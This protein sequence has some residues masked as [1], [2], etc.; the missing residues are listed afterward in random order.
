MQPF[1]SSTSFPPTYYPALTPT[2]DGKLDEGLLGKSTSTKGVNVL[3][4]GIPLDARACERT[5]ARPAPPKQRHSRILAHL[6]PPAASNNTR[7]AQREIG[8][9]L[10][11]P[12]GRA[13]PLEPPRRAPSALDWGCRANVRRSSI[14]DPCPSSMPSSPSC[15]RFASQFL[16]RAPLRRL[17]RR[18]HRPKSPGRG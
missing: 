6:E 9:G 11:T 4:L 8:S 16:L 12:V 14:A 1:H 5:T 10:S 7:A 15:Q 17:L 3:E 18:R 13:S 2:A